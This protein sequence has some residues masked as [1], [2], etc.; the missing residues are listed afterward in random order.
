MHKRFII[1]LAAAVIFT[2][3]SCEGKKFFGGKDEAQKKGNNPSV[4]RANNVDLKQ[5]S[6]EEEKSETV[7]EKPESKKEAN[8]NTGLS[9]AFVPLSQS[10]IIKG[11]YL[12]Y[13]LSLY[14]K[15]GDFKGSR[16]AL[17]KLVQRYGFLV[18]ASTDIS[19][20]RDSVTVQASVKSDSM[21]DF[22][23][24]LENIGSLYSENITVSD[25][26]GEMV[27]EEIKSRTEK[28]RIERKNAAMG[29]ITAARRTWE[30]VESSLE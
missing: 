5:P 19:A 22:L 1:V 27:L 29:Q 9:Q 20:P 24:E 26:T 14:Y 28:I 12:E 21:Y 18:S 3:A 11:R 13:S 2:A 7:S 17:M 23:Y 6:G 30:D 15:T 25:H 10:N 16:L 8:D 4:T